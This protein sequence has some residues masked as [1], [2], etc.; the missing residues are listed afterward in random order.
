[1]T[2]TVFDTT[3]DELA[4]RRTIE[5][6]S[7]A[8]CR[9]RSDEIMALWDEDCRWSVPDMKG[10]EDVRGKEL[11]C[12][13]FEGAQDLFSFVFL[14]CTPGHI[15]IK[16]DRAWVRTYTTERL[17]DLEGTIR[18]AVGRYDDQL[19]KRDGKWLFSERVWYILHSQEA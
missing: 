9:R 11:I 15:R 16:G 10:L 13:T 12:A 4:I 5:E 19:I 8:V 7:D 18:N 14:V 3:V 6:Y 1:M 17:V 2:P